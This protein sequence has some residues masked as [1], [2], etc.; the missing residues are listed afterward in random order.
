MQKMGTSK[1]GCQA[2]KLDAQKL[3]EGTA[4]RSV[5]FAQTKPAPTTP[6]K[7]SVCSVE[8]DAKS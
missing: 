6:T 2:E 8:R 3:I 7:L 1:F 5:G 4:H